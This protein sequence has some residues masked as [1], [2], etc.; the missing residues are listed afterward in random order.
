MGYCIFGLIVGPMLLPDEI[1]HWI[2]DHG[3]SGDE[4]VSPVDY[5]IVDS[6]VC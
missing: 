2:R 6:G 4:H 5:N 3:V 1:W